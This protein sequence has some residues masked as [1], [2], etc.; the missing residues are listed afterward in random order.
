MGGE[1]YQLSSTGG[2]TNTSRVGLGSPNQSIKHK[3][4]TRNQSHCM[5]LNGIYALR[6]RIILAGAEE[7]KGA[8]M[9]YVP[10]TLTSPPLA[11][12][13]GATLLAG[14]SVPVALGVVVGSEKFGGTVRVRPVCVL[15]ST[16]SVD[17]G[18]MESVELVGAE[19]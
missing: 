14:E 2:G 8:G 3:H 18:S 11:L 15:G 7:D 16:E 13:V 12:G 4:E 5:G 10:M 19:P 9:A 17:V 1:G 6:T